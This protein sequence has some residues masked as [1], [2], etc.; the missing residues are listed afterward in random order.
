MGKVILSW[1]DYWDKVYGCWMG[2]NCGG[3]LGAPMEGRKEILDLDW[4]PKLEEGGIPNDDLEMQ[5][6]WLEAMEK[7]GFDLDAQK[8]AE[9]WLNHIFYNW[10]EYGLN[11][12]NL[13]KGLR[14][15][16]SGAF[17][18]WFKN[19]M[20]C[21]IRSEIWACLAPGCPNLAARYA[22]QD[23]IVDHA[24]GESVYGEMFFAAVESAAFL[25]SDREELLDI[26]LRMIPP[27]CHTAQAIRDTRNWFSENPDWKEI[28][29]RILEKYGHPNVTDSVQNIAFTVLGW[30]AG[31]GDFGKSI[32]TAVNCGYDTDCTGATL[33]AIL[34]VILGGKGLPERWTAP[35]GEEIAT[36]ESW[37]GLQ[38]FTAPTNLRELT[39]RTCSMGRK[40]LTYF[41]APVIISE[42]RETDLSEVDS[43][44]FEPDDLIRS[45]WHRDPYQVEFRLSSLNLTLDYLGSPAVKADIPKKVRVKLENPNPVPLKLR[46]KLTPPRG[47]RSHPGGEQAISIPPK[48]KIW[49]DY[50]LL[51]KASR[52]DV[53]NKAILNL[54]I[55]DRPAPEAVPIVLV[56][57]SKWLIVGPFPDEGGSSLENLLPPE[58]EFD[59]DGIW[60]GAEG[61]MVSWE[62][63]WFE[64]NQLD[65]E[66]IFGGKPGAILMRHYLRSPDD[67]PARIG[68]PT[69][70]GI[71]VRLNG[72]E[73]IRTNDPNHIPRP[74][75][76]GYPP[77]YVNTNLR[78]GWNELEIKLVRYDKPIEAHFILCDVGLVPGFADVLESRFPW[79]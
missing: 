7:E 30:L 38:N 33:G 54:D 25:I 37:G 41:D 56:G 62:E 24:G 19:S 50:E 28:R 13:K 75:Y 73:I 67:R 52:V 49:M 53:S 77:Y 32:C 16:V 78:A 76:G 48:G 17:N 68:F 79:D 66:P 18:N 5:L 63:Y 23:A 10:D 69:N 70:G 60:K 14:P 20:G 46:A 51:G 2:K 55:S 42:K 43:I 4:Y 35:L 40:L 65:L 36:N 58:E 34:G 15:P 21:P 6:I 27:E 72:R 57:A 22:Y 1:E 29:G 61:R 45:L 31:D 59:I 26:G 12:T 64:E 9:Y 11:K 47:W 39:D 74:N 8:L 71:R 44:G 3:T